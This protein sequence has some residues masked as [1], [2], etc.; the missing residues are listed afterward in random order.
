MWATGIVNMAVWICSVLVTIF[1]CRPIQGA[2]EF[3]IVHK[4][5]VS[6]LHFF[7]VMA[8][9]NIMTDLILCTFP[10]PLFWRLKL[11]LNER[12]PL[13]ILFAFGFL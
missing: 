8:A 4:Q 11:P 6:I 2:W 9:F 12:I 1:Q 3:D 5:C 10:M 13:C 7:Y